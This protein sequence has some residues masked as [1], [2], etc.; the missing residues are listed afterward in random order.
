M[1]SHDHVI[2]LMGS[3]FNEGVLLDTNHRWI[4]N[5]SVSLHH[6]PLYLP[7]PKSIPISVTSPTPLRSSLS[8]LFHP[9]SLHSLF[10]WYPF[11]CHY[12][13]LISC[14]SSPPPI[15]VFPCFTLVSFVPSPWLSQANPAALSL[16][17]SRPFMYFTPVQILLLIPTS[18][19]PHYDLT[20]VSSVQL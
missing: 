10:H 11:P 15:P 17:N 19:H 4:S 14:I 18:F 9:L 1:D 2:G 6:P 7:S 13:P 3:A 12:D 20:I 16:L 8:P 5:K